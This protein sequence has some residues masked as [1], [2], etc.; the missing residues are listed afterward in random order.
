MRQLVYDTDHQSEDLIAANYPSR[1]QPW[2]EN[3]E[4]PPKDSW[5][6]ER[7]GDGLEAVLEKWQSG[8]F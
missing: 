2:R 8:T 7:T 4:T 5:Q 3:A 6:I 1:W